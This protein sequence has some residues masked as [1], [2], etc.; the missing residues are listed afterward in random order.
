MKILITQP[1][2]LPWI[3]YFDLISKTDII[4]F[5]D[6]VQ[7]EKRSWQQR[8]RIKTAN[9]LEWITLPVF[10]K[11]KRS[12]L[13][14]DV[15]I[16]VS[17]KSIKKIKK[18]IELNYQKSLYSNSYLDDFNKCFE[19][20]LKKKKLLNF[21]IKLIKFFLD[22]LKIKK[23]IFFSSDLNISS[24]K[25]EKILSIC[26]HFKANQ[27]IT[28]EGANKYLKDYLHLFD[29]HQIEIFT[30]SYCH[31]LYK[32]CFPPFSSHASIIDLIFNE[33]KESLNILNVGSL[34]L[35]K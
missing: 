5:L 26:K 12:Q 19:D 28:T 11:G 16:D 31:P 21:N 9:G 17:N 14:K 30:H 18:T 27:Y 10:S 35:F 7:F 23:E 33:G 8:N 20:N 4:V 29:Q 3:G 13:I 22:I 15:N 6:D 34:K 32:Q 24:S 25:G 2:F 1:T